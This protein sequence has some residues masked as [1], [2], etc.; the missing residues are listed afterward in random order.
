MPAPAYNAVTP[1]TT[2]QPTPTAV[3]L[4]RNRDTAW[5][6]RPLQSS[7][8]ATPEKP[9]KVDWGPAVREY[10]RRAFESNQGH[11]WRRHAGEA[12]GDDQLLRREGRA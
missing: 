7:M 4:P 12:E 3:G 11:L 5:A 9:K 8:S 1:R 2:L 6:D 10:V